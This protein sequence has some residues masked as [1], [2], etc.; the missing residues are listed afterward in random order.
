L[1]GWVH[2]T[3]A[4]LPQGRCKWVDT[5]PPKEP[6]DDDEE[7]EEEQ[8]QVEPEVGPPLLHPLQND[9]RSYRLLSGRSAPLDIVDTASLLMQYAFFIHIRSWF[10]H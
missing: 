2:H 3:Q 4:I 5:T 9:D 7:E 6:S 8:P 10:S 1:S